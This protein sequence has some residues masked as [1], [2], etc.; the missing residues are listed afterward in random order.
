MLALLIASSLTLAPLPAPN[1]EGNMMHISPPNDKLDL[2]KPDDVVKLCLLSVR[3]EKAGNPQF[4][5][6]VIHRLSKQ[7]QYWVRMS[8]TV[9]VKGV[10]AGMDVMKA[11]IDYNNMTKEQRDAM[12]NLQLN[13]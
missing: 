9:Y 3:E 12:Q 8:C 10:V 5:N 7:D 4:L 1:G 13:Y 11:M 2:T 6:R